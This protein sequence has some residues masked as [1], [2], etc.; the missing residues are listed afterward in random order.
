MKPYVMTCRLRGTSTGAK[1]LT[2]PATWELSGGI[3]VNVRV[4]NRETGEDIHF[5][6]TACKRGQSIV[7]YVPKK[8]ATM[9]LCVGDLL[10]MELIPTDEIG[11][12]GAHV[13][14]EEDDEDW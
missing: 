11:S 13:S 3:S 1:Y 7:V 8:L 4:T 6:R 12:T 2:V 14:A 9:Y 10:D 5:I